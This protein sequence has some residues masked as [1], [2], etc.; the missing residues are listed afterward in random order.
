MTTQKKSGWVVN[1]TASGPVS[2]QSDI[3]AFVHRARSA[4]VG[5]PG[6]LLFGMD[7]TASREASW[8]QACQIQGE[9]FSETATLG[10]LSVQLAYYRGFGEFRAS[11][12]LSDTRK[13]L[14][15]M[16]G[17]NC[18]GGQT[19]IGRLLRHV[20]S[21]TRKQRIQAVVFVGDAFE[22]DLDAVCHQAGELGV[23]GVPVFI[24]HE[25]GDALARR[26]FE[27]IA[28]L[29]KGVCCPF[30]GD[31]AQQLRDLLAAVAVY[32]AGGRKVL[33]DFSARRGGAAL[34]LTHRFGK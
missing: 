27:Q 15:A 28:R 23:L 26:A 12:W 3:D 14:R 4:P 19:Q 32:A 18:L 24:F 22:E 20:I 2:S 34:Q 29:T 9:M 8:D 21:E 33:Q 5:G 10:G 1:K 30:D 25:G 31:S 13:L 6:R 17:V 11:A 16:T 7:A